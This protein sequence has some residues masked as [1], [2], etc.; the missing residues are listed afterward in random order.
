MSAPKSLQNYLFNL[1]NTHFLSD[2]VYSKIQFRVP[3]L[4]LIT[5]IIFF[6][7]SRGN[8]ASTHTTHNIYCTIFPFL[9]YCGLN[10][11]TYLLYICTHFYGRLNSSGLM[12]L[13]FLPEDH[14]SHLVFLITTQMSLFKQQKLLVTTRLSS[15]YM[16]KLCG[17]HICPSPTVQFIVR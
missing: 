15:P 12:T 8:L 4:S 2:F 6:L 13:E 16:A 14:I 11:L 3:D 1:P 9:A 17:G 5:K 10:W 7:F